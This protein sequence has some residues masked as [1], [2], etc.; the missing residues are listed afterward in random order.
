MAKLLPAVDIET[1]EPLSEHEVLVALVRDLPADA[2]V[3]HACATL[4]RKYSDLAA[5]DVH[6]ISACPFWA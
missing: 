4:N 5:E 1:I 6:L 3:L 2:I